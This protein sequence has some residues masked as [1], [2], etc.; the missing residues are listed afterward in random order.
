MAAGASP[1]SEA[2]GK[3]VPG[4]S[5]AGT[6]PTLLSWHW[7]RVVHL[8]RTSCRMRHTSMPAPPEPLWSRWGKQAPITCLPV[9]GRPGAAC[10]VLPILHAYPAVGIPHNHG[11]KRVHA[12]THPISALSPAALLLPVPSSRSR[13]RRSSTARGAKACVENAG[14]PARWWHN[15]DTGR[16]GF[17]SGAPHRPHANR[18]HPAESHRPHISGAQEPPPAST[19]GPCVAPHALSTRVHTL[20]ETAN[21]YGAFF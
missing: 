19:L 18:A 15:T 8:C 13:S 17:R 6:A 10:I 14:F 21:H 9:P 5:L 11:K 4:Q 7:L 2:T 1:G 3:R 20:Q 16:L 12:C